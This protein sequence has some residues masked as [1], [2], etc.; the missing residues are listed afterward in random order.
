M[1]EWL[2]YRLADFVMFSPRVYYRQFERL[3]EAV[4]PLQILALA[5]GLFLVRT[6]HAPSAMASRT[7][8]VVLGAAWLFVGWEYLW[9]DYAEIFLGAAYIT[10]LFILEG[11]ALL[12]LA[13]YPDGLALHKPANP[14]LPVG[15]VTVTIPVLFYPLLA[16]MMG[17]SWHAAEVFG[18]APDPTA[19]GTLAIMSLS[20]LRARPLLMMVPTAWCVLSALTLWTM[21]RPDIWFVALIVLAIVI[22]AF[23][24]RR[25]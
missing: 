16:P 5:F 10:P 15:V 23:F 1:Q 6:V 2:S 13:A 21:D 4:W 20:R 25:A 7:A 8:A 14:H 18:I 17:R 9:Q 24:G 3:N 22:L 19:L 12:G 11:V